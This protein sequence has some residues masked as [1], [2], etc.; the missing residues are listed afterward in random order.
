MKKIREKNNLKTTF[1]EFTTLIAF[2]YFARKK[3]DYAVI[4][5]GLGG[6]FDATN[7]INPQICAIT[8]ISKDHQEILGNSL[9]KIAFEK[10]G[11]IKKNKTI[12]TTEN[13]KIC[14]KVFKRISRKK[15]A[16]LKQIK[17]F[18]KLKLKM[19]GKHQQKN[20]NLA[21]QIIKE[22][23]L[24]I[25]DE[26]I[27]QA[28]FETKI[29]GR[30]EVINEKPK[31]IIDSSHNKEGIKTLE[32][33]IKN[34]KN[35]KILLIGLSKDKPISMIKNI[36]KEFDEVVISRSDFKPQSIENILKDLWQY[37]QNSIGF[38]KLSEA[39][40]YT[41]KKLNKNDTMIV[42][43]SIYFIGNYLKLK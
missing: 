14:I 5:V 9:E 10:A 16:K 37:N 43:G 35:K 39:K 3:I 12:L 25:S 40:K 31:I 19:K 17:N 26:I 30:Y 27:N 22:L 8:N 1:F 18:E 7:I 33:L 42:T 4:E 36:A 2:N 13:K 28:L 6:R 41:I 34:E 29:K 11:I 24:G 23:N 21:K 38:D 32:K 15:R 20:A